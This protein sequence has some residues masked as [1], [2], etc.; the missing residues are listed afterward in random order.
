M[1]QII[2][3]MSSGETALVECPVPSAER[4]QVLIKTQVSLIS[5]GTERMLVEFGQAGLLGKAMAQPEKVRMVADKVRTDGLHATVEAVRSKLEQ[6]IALGYCNAGTVRGVGEGVNRFTVGDRVASC[7]PHAEV[8][9]V[10]ENLCA[11]I[12]DSVSYEAASFTVLA[13]I[14]LQGIRLCAPTLGEAVVVIGTGLIG[15]IT[16][17]LLKA[18]GCR[19]LA[20]DVDDEKLAL[21]QQFGAQVCNIARGH[22]PVCAGMD[23][24][25]RRGVDAVL[26]TAST[27]S[28]DPVSQAARMSRKRGRIVLVGVTGLELR[29][30]EFYEKELTFQVSCSYGPG[31]YDEEYEKLGNDYPVGYVRWTENRN[32]EAV[33]DMLS[34]GAIDTETLV[35]RRFPFAD[36]SRA[37]E[38]LRTDRAALGLLLEYPPAEKSTLATTV[39]LD[40]DRNARRSDNASVA[41][42]SARVVCTFVGAGNYGSRVLIPAFRKTDA[43]LHT[44]VTSG[45]LSASYQGRKALFRFATTDLNEALGREEV[46]TVVIA[47]RHDKHAEIAIKALAAG[48]HVFVEKP[49]AIT[50]DELERLIT[51]YSRPVT[52]PLLMVG[53]NRRFAPHVLAVKRLLSEVTEPKAFIMTMNAGGVP[54]DHWIHDPKIGGGRI[55]GEGCHHID[56]MR[57]LAGSAI[58]HA[59]ARRIDT[60]FAGNEDNAA[61][62]LGFEDGSMGTIHYLANGHPGFPKERIEVFAAGRVLQIDNF[63]RLRAHGWNGLGRRRR[64][65]QDKGQNACAQAFVKAVGRGEPA[66]IPI[67]EIFEVA[68]V[69]IDVARQLREQI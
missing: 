20:V 57:H 44:L 31:R 33:L 54:A 60:K 66:P 61:I 15:L 17:Q 53:Y 21:A 13:A 16:V 12:P 9:R 47:T 35:T 67:D 18:H 62:T 6:P 37:Y 68:R 48:K 65:R 59:Q 38:Q 34:E 64:F 52:Q 11:H 26:I 45:G 24:S 8:V 2:Q 46:N 42:S 41:R 28:S 22:D 23:F 63:L 55:I 51:F 58:T 5:A 39:R 10:P 50:Y 32:F 56:L 29:R 14:G 49:L 27:K 19:V 4:G 69:S 30:S 25:R 7:G 40:F 36:A 43:D 3:N 1:K